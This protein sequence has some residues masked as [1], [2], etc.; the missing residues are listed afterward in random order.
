MNGLVPLKGVRLVF[1]ENGEVVVKEKNRVDSSD[2]LITKRLAIVGN[3]VRSLNMGHLLAWG[4]NYGWISAAKLDGDEEFLNEYM[5]LCMSAPVRVGDRVKVLGNNWFY[6]GESIVTK[7]DVI[8]DFCELRETIAGR[9]IYSRSLVFNFNEEQ[10][11]AFKNKRRYFN[12]WRNS[13]D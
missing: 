6:S 8:G 1:Q 12:I 5:A 2:M 9:S 11:D 3:R 13:N 10:L 4:F 7:V